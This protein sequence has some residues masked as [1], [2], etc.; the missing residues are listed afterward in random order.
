MRESLL[1][2]MVIGLIGLFITTG[3]VQGGQSNVWTAKLCDFETQADFARWQLVN[4]PGAT[5]PVFKPSSEHVTSGKHS[6]CF[7]VKGG[8]G[9]F[10]LMMLT[11]KNIPMQD[12]TPYDYLVV[13][14]F[15]PLDY[16]VPL[17][18]LATN[19][20]VR[21]DAIVWSQGADAPLWDSCLRQIVVQPGQQT[22]RL[23]VKDVAR[24]PHVTVFRFVFIDPLQ[25]YTL[26]FDNLRLRRRLRSWRHR[27]GLERQ[28]S[29]IESR[30]QAFQGHAD[31]LKP[32]VE[33]LKESILASEKDGKSLKPARHS[34][35]DYV[36]W[37]DRSDAIAAEL[38]NLNRTLADCL[39]QSAGQTL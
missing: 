38:A 14:V 12:W 35:L 37:R 1:S 13:D 11:G 17:D 27:R 5:L 16:P 2:A 39:P 36:L 8:A 6:A 3:S 30:M 21:D 31:A 33:K 23:R 20:S 28:L 19:E 9:T 34:L 32:E 10:P 26:Y 25:S 4:Q 22:L 29:E 18:I 24:S 7:E 15:N